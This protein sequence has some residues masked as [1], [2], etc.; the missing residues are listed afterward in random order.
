LALLI[1]RGDQ[2]HWMPSALGN[3]A[4]RV[5]LASAVFATAAV[6]AQFGLLLRLTGQWLPAFLQNWRRAWGWDKPSIW[7]A[8]CRTWRDCT[9]ARWDHWLR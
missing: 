4:W 8:T 9:C 7:R 3:V 6:L 2:A 1:A 5:N